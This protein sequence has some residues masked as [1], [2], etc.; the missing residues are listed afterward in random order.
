VAYPGSFTSNILVLGRAPT[1]VTNPLIMSAYLVAWLAINFSPFDVVYSIARQRHV[2]TL[3]TF[4][5]RIDNF[6]SAFGL[7]M[8]CR[9]SF[10]QGIA[11]GLMMHWGGAALSI[12]RGENTFQNT[13]PNVYYYILSLSAFYF[14]AVRG[15]APQ[16]D[17]AM[18]ARECMRQSMWFECLVLLGALRGTFAC[19]RDQIDG[20]VKLGLTSAQ[21]VANALGL[22]YWADETNKGEKT[23]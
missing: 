12:F 1:A 17:N 23:Q 21:S 19:V 5:A 22:V 11:A 4:L 15:C 3:I 7:V 6:A 10:P 8:L 2:I 16:A 20:V 14:F 9:N 18:F 13:L